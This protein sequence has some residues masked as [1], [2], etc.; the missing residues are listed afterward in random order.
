MISLDTVNPKDQMF[1]YVRSLDAEGA[2]D[3]IPHSIL[4]RKAADIIPDQL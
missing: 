1:M 4:F 2:F 3:V